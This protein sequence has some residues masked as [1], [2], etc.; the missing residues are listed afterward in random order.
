VSCSA[1]GGLLRVRTDTLAVCSDLLCRRVPADPHASR[2]VI[3]CSV[4][5]PV[6]PCTN[7]SVRSDRGVC[8]CLGDAS[9]SMHMRT[10]LP[11]THRRAC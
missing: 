2:V 8:A 10:A 11:D 6:A 3:T 7:A 4:S 1:A 5:S 9:R